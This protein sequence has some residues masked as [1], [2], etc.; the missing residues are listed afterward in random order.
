MNVQLAVKIKRTFQSISFHGGQAY[1]CHDPRQTLGYITSS[2]AVDEC[3]DCQK[4]AA[5]TLQ[6]SYFCVEQAA[7]MALLPVSEVK[8]VPTAVLA[9]HIIHLAALQKLDS[10][11]GNGHN[12]K[13]K[14]NDILKLEEFHFHLTR[15][16]SISRILPLYFY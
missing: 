13:L 6:D 11:I 9:E 5:V 4:S 16:T 3:R 10:N 14:F 7:S 2:C 12:I 15:K 1:L 8:E